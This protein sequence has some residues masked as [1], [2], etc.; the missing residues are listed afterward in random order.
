MPPREIARIGNPVLRKVAESVDPRE[1]KTAAFQSLIDDM[2]ET[3]RSEPGIGLAA[4]QV[5]VS[6]RLA[7]LEN[8]GEGADA[9]GL[10]VCVNP[11]FRYRSEEQ[12]EGWEGCLSV[13]NLR[14]RVRRHR[15][16]EIEFLDRAGTRRTLRTDRFL[17]IVLQ[18]ECD[19]LD[20]I[21]FVDRADTRTLCQLDE[22]E[23]YQAG[24]GDAA[25]A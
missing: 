10:L 13:D 8:P 15:A 19:H 9:F 1:I 11:V 4:P 16:V 6:K 17:S 3:M 18:H 12:V 24:G 25:V 2:V 7:V 21:L 5:S 20:G 22:F 23:R 14:G